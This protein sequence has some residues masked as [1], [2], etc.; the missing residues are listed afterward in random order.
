MSFVYF[1]MSK[2]ITEQVALLKNNLSPGWTEE[3]ATEL[4][5][6]RSNRLAR[7]H[8]HTHTHTHTQIAKINPFVSFTQS[9]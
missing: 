3:R 8:T 7:T 5:H 2:C 1:K 6:Q 9:I 4:R